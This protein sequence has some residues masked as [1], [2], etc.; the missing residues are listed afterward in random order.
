MELQNQWR[1]TYDELSYK[2]MCTFYSNYVDTYGYHDQYNRSWWDNF[3]DQLSGAKIWV[4]ELGGHTGGLA[5]RI[6]KNHK[7][8]ANWINF[9]IDR[10]ALYDNSVCDDPRYIPLH[11]NDYLWNMP[12]RVTKLKGY[13]LVFVAAHVLEHLKEAQVIS[14]LDKIVIHCKYAGVEIPLEPRRRNVNWKDFDGSHILE[15]G[16]VELIELFRDRGFKVEHDGLWNAKLT[17][18]EGIYDDTMNTKDNSDKWRKNYSRMTYD[19]QRKYYNTILN[20]TCDQRQYT[21]EY[22]EKP[23]NNMLKD[24]ELK[25]IELGGYQGEL[26]HRILR[27]YS[28]IVAWDN[29]EITDRARTNSVCNDG[30]YRPIITNEFLWDIGYVA[31]E[32]KYNVFLSSHTIE[33]ISTADFK[34]L[35]DT[36]IRHCDYCILEIPMP[37]NVPKNDLNWKGFDGTHILDIPWEEILEILYRAGFT[38]FELSDGRGW[39]YFGWKELKNDTT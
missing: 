39:N 7:N 9:D 12:E 17:K 13:R 36:V 2:Q 15:I 14:L 24:K 11:L 3:F 22:I 18:L 32:E 4:I 26:A 29:F 38:Q 33:H 8:I 37:Y 28:N 21:I 19:D 16:W 10:T 6:L 27:K 31:L 35:V 34:K 1:E 25:I 5:K 30:R 23:F 20:L